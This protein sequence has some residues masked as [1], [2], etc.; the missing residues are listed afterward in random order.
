MSPETAQWLHSMSFSG[1]IASIFL[2]FVF[3]T[4]ACIDENRKGDRALVGYLMMFTFFSSIIGVWL[5]AVSGV[6]L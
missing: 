6:H 5:Y 3:Y 4:W 2:F 1:T